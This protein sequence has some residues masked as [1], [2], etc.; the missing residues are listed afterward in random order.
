MKP[1]IKPGEGDR[2]SMYNWVNLFNIT[3]K[4][5]RQLYYFHTCK[6]C[7]DIMPLPKVDKPNK[8]MLA[9]LCM[10]FQDFPEDIKNMINTIFTRQ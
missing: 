5:V 1:E 7:H 9:I 6:G 3:F 8:F 10:S 4:M 2:L